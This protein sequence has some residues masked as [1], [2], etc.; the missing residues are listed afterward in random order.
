MSYVYALLVVLV[1][2]LIFVFSYYMNSKIKV[3]CD[4]NEMCNNCAIES[5]Y[6]KVTKEE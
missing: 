3:E 4:E 1:L 5:C 2:S 6:R